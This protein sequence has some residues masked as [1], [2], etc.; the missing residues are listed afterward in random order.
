MGRTKDGVLHFVLPAEPKR[1]GMNEC[2]HNDTDQFS[3]NRRFGSKC[4]FVTD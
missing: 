2:E 3:D 4:T 1:D